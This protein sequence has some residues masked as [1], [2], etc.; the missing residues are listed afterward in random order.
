MQ[1]KNCL[2]GKALKWID[3]MYGDDC[4]KKALDLLDSFYLDG[5]AE[6]AVHKML[7]APIMNKR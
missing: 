3:Y 5:I 6:T 1:L 7:A 2:D 4:Y